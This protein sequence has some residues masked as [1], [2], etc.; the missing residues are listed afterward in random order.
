MRA[1]ARDAW[2]TEA[3][4]CAAFVVRPEALALFAARGALSSWLDETGQRWVRRD[5]AA[6]LFRSRSAVAG[7]R[8][9][10]LGTL[11]SVVLGAPRKE[12]GLAV[13]ASRPPT[14][15][16]ELSVR[17]ATDPL[18]SPYGRTG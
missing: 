2:L 14:R 17:A 12:S 15:E 5:A 7:E 11:G 3:E 16:R 1:S 8:A 6:N 4:V 13:R 9:D 10:A 18:R